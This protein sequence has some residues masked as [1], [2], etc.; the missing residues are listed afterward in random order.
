MVDSEAVATVDTEAVDSEDSME[1][2]ASEEDT[3]EVDSASQDLLP[4]LTPR[5]SRSTREVVDSEA[6]DSQD[7]LL[8]PTLRLNPS[9]READSVVDSRAPLPEL[10]HR[11]SPS[12][13]E[14]VVDSPE[15]SVVVSEDSQAEPQVPT[16]IPRLLVDKQ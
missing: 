15:D 13:R 12:T 4:M 16:P 10:A 14:V 6:V 7:R 9:T 2:E 8:V 1:V 3:R 5:P 11:L